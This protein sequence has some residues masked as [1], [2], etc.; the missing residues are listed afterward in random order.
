MRL[1]TKNPKDNVLD[2]DI[3]NF[4][5]ETIED[6]YKQKHDEH[7]YYDLIFIATE[8]CKAEV[9]NKTIKRSMFILINLFN[10][11]SRVS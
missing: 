6:K 11:C 3:I 2:A 9:P 4:I 8:M 5:N 10:I 7:A 1:K